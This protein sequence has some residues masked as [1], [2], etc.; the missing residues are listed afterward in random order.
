[1][2]GGVAL[3]KQFKAIGS[4]PESERE[5]ARTAAMQSMRSLGQTRREE[6]GTLLSGEQLEMYDEAEEEI[7]AGLHGAP[8]R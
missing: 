1:M 2:D 6:V 8:R 3:R 4:L 5:E 7:V